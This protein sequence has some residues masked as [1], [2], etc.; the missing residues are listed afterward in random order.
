M[1]NSLGLISAASIHESAQFTLNEAKSIAQQSL[2]K[3]ASSKDFAIKFAIA[4]GDSFDAATVEDLRQEW[5]AGDFGSLPTIEFRSAAEIN[6]ANG[7]FSADTNTIYLSREYVEQNGSDV[8]AIAN[9]LLEEIG[10]SVD[11]R[12]NVTDAPGDEGAIFSALAQG[13]QIDAPTLQTLKAEDDKA[14]ITLD[15]Q[16][17]QIEQAEP[18]LTQVI[19]RLDEMVAGLDKY[20]DTLQS[21]I[22]SEVFF[23]N[24]LP[25]LGDKL[26]QVDKFIDNLEK[27]NTAVSVLQKAVD[28]LQKIGEPTSEDIQNILFNA[29]GT[30][31]NELK[32]LQDLNGDN[33]I[34]KE[35][36]IVNDEVKLKLRLSDSDTYE[37]PFADALGLPGLKLSIDGE[38]KVDLTFNSDFT[39]GVHKDNGFFLDTSTKDELSIGV[40]AALPSSGATGDLGYLQLG[41]T[42]K[43]SNFNST[44]SID[45]ND[46]NK[47]NQLTA[48]EINTKLT[49]GADIKL[50]LVSGFNDF[51]VLPKIH[52]DFNLNWSLDNPTAA[53]KVAF[54]NV[55]LD[56]GSFFN[57][58]ARPIL[59]KIQQVTKPLKP[60]TDALTAEIPLFK[61]IGS[62]ANFLDFDTDGKITLLDLAKAY[63]PSLKTE[64]ISAAAEIINLANNIP[65]SDLLISLGS[66]DLGGVDVGATGFDL[67][68]VTPNITGSAANATDQI[69]DG[70]AKNFIT[71]LNTIPGGGFQFP[72]LNKPETAFN[73]LLGKSVDLFTY[74]MPTLE[75]GFK[76][77]E[78]FSIIGP[79]G[80]TIKGNVGAKVDLAFGYDTY[81]LQLFKDS[82]KTS[83]I[84]DGFYVSDHRANP[85][86]TGKDAPEA[87]LSASLRAFG[88]LELAAAR[89]GVGGGI[90]ANMF[91]DLVDG[92]E[93]EGK[94]DGEIRPSEFSAAFSSNPASLFNL[95]GELTAGLE[96]YAEVGWPDKKFLGKSLG[97]RWTWESPKVVLATFGTKS[98]STAPPPPPIL[99]TNL[100]GGTLRLNM[101]PNA[102]DRKTFDTKDGAETFTVAFK[103]GSTVTVTAFGFTQDY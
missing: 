81:G 74:D 9:V 57:D 77:E 48:S 56:L 38:A 59:D 67:S 103:N 37:I 54:N 23:K 3:I 13:V 85:D 73:L 75:V 51:K 46:A 95:Y 72:I 43:G 83:D 101:G 22:K 30:G 102:G 55:Q 84:F 99:A 28:D 98:E 10:H 50:H 14:T 65:T 82:K 94:S 60:L 32:L 88:A 100:G 41:I 4:F 36:I 2:S 64:F 18:A 76:F 61:K 42:D 29:L 12:I 26:T 52:T 87:T 66:F 6:G 68:S 27:V 92:G 40:K 93:S 17:I 89:G 16:V 44:F 45:L 8:S 39:F 21:L 58:F 80:A 90:Y 78:F 7:A 63:N 1:S 79:L 70:A 31:A 96:A 91:A 25:L 24:N 53:P 69:P 97:E 62:A 19:S 71:K 34:T 86:G 33:K 49:G 47:D 20:L 11:S 15:G 35:D 5:L